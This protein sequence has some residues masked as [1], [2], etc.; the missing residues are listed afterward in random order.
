LLLILFT[1]QEKRLGD[2]VAGTI[3]VQ[4]GQAIA[5]QQIT[6]SSAASDLALRL[7]ETGK[8][9]TITPHE[10]ATIRKY[11]YRYPGLD[12]AMKNDVSDRLARQLLQ[13]IEL[14]NRPPTMDSHLMLESIYLAYQ[15]QFRE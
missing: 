8:I 14:D 7:I 15:Q 13:R 11:L 2:W 3:L 6:L 12:P 4:E 5:N 1:T 10:F 9:A